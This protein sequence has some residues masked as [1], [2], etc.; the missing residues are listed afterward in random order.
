MDI[1]SPPLSL[2]AQLVLTVELL[3]DDVSSSTATLKHLYVNVSS[4][5]LSQPRL[6]TNMT[7]LA[8]FTLPFACR[9]PAPIL[10]TLLCVKVSD[11]ARGEISLWCWSASGGSIRATLLVNCPS[12]SG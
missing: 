12:V 5:K 1:I 4:E 3:S 10:R 6:N 11:A 2:T 9:D 7:T 8:P